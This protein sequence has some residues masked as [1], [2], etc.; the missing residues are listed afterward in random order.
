MTRTERFV[1]AMGR[2]LEAEGVPRIGGR[3][4][5]FLLLQQGAVSLDD[6][7]DQLAV[8]KTS[9]STN[10]RLLEQRGLIERETVPGDRRDYYRAADD[11]TRV[12]EI[13]LER[14]RRMG[15][16]LRDGGDAAGS[17]AVQG[18]LRTMLRFNEDALARLEKLLSGWKHRGR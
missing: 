2:H 15:D 5:G 6:L 12:L 10:A 17:R 4:Y 14:V 8:S 18:R 9:V 3:L 16:L 1:E 13:A 11:Q 7:A